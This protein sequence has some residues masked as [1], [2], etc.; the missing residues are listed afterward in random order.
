MPKVEDIFLKLNSAK[1][2]CTL[3]ICTGYHQIIC[4]KGSIPKTVFKSPFGKYE[5]VKVPF[6]LAQAPAYF[7]ELINKVVK[8]SLFAIAYLDD[9][10][11]YSKTAEEHLDHL[12]QVFHKLHNA[13]LSMKLN[14]CHF[15]TKEIQ[16]LGH[17]LSTTGIKPVP[18]KTTAIKLMKSLKNDKQVRAFFGLFGYYCKFIK[19][20]DQITKSLR[21]LTHHDAKFDWTS[22][23]YAAFNTLKIALI[24]TPILH[25]PNPSKCYI[26]YTD[27]SDDACGDELLQEQ[28][29]Q[30]LLVAFLFHTSTETQHKW[31][32]PKK[33]SMEYAML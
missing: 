25:Y 15:F 16:S 19:N 21:A 26:V 7:K 18:S 1:Y 28:I 24:I 32:T 5:Y 14:R 22:G 8:D 10:I 29:G 23:H 2:F 4:I 20:F 33:K 30:E 13:E 9:I 11:I 31:S 3:N 12:Q 6:G 17:V 27:T